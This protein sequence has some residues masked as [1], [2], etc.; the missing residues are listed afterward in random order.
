MKFFVSESDHADL[1]NI[2][3]SVFPNASD[4]VKMFLNHSITYSVQNHHRL[5]DGTKMLLAY[6]FLFG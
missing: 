2:L 4:K 1:S 5:D 3:E 6:A